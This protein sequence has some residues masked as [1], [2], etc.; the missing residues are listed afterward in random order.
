ME[1]NR[2]WFLYF[3][4]L[5]VFLGSETGLVICWRAF[6]LVRLIFYMTRAL[7][8]GAVVGICWA[9]GRLLRWYANRKKNG[10]EIRVAAKVDS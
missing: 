8:A 5:F 6:I 4:L 9:L 7:L 2:Y 3:G 1:S 10:R